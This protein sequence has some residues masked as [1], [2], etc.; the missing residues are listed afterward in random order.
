[1]EYFHQPHLELFHD[2]N[3]SNNAT[4]HQ[5][6]FWVKGEGY[7]D[8]GGTFRSADYLRLPGGF[9]RL[10]AQQ[11]TLPLF[12]TAP[13]ASVLFRAYLDQWQ[14]GWLPRLTFRRSTGETSLGAEAR[15]HRSLRWGRIEEASGLPE[16][17]VGPEQDVK[18]YQ[19]HG[20]KAIASLY[21]SHLTR[22]L[23]W[24]AVQGDVQM[25]YSRY[26]HYEE[27][28]FSR[29]FRKPY[30]FVNPRLG[31]TFNPEHAVSGYLS[32]ALAHRE[33]RLKSLYDGEEAGS[34]FLPQFERNRDNSFDYD[35]P[36]VKPE[37]LVDLEVG[38]SINRERYRITGTAYLMDFRNEIVPSGGLDQFGVPRTGNADHSRHIGV[39]LE[40]IARLG[41]GLGVQANATLSRNRFVRFTEFN[42]ESD[43]STAGTER[44]G[45]PIAGF[46]DHIANLG[47]TYSRSGL[48]ASL[49]AKYTGRQYIDNSGGKDPGGAHNSDL[50]IAP[51]VLLN[52]SMQYGFSARSAL[53]GLKLALDVNNLLDEKVLLY[54]NVGPAGPQF[55]PAATRHLFASLQYTLR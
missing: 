52:A 3:P 44:D 17:L 26:R 14:V 4:L 8:F 39:E 36:L 53:S 48:A 43:A 51:F 49:N 2:W 54:G 38:G 20:E 45:N 40:G 28:F 5:A 37:R 24:L 6:L 13:D 23:D 15:L 31:V 12:I 47:L 18:V 34:G 21:G 16:H 32:I 25:T 33:P 11:R 27:Q 35:N 55:F 30:L 42:V 10:D 19:F 1:M 29:S 50:E 46:P 7:F 22:P 41:A 9:R